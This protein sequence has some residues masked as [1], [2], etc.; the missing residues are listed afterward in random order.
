MIGR[1]TVAVATRIPPDGPT[2]ELHATQADLWGMFGQVVEQRTER[3]ELLTFVRVRPGGRRA[4]QSA[5]AGRPYCRL[6]D[7]Q[8]RSTTGGTAA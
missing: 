2:R 3:G 7:A 6:S 5:V 1:T 4:L 8:P